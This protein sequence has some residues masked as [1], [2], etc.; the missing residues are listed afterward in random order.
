[1]FTASSRPH[2]YGCSLI[3]LFSSFPNS[4][5]RCCRAFSQNTLKW[6][7]GE[8]SLSAIFVIV[9]SFKLVSV[10]AFTL[11]VKVDQ[12]FLTSLQWEALRTNYYFHSPPVTFSYK[13][14]I[15]KISN[16]KTAGKNYLFIYDFTMFNKI[17]KGGIKHS[18]IALFNL[19]LW[20]CLQLIAQLL[21]TITFIKSQRTLSIQPK[22]NECFEKRFPRYNIKVRIEFWSEKSSHNSFFLH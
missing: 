21:V 13:F 22:K 12:D 11:V 3:F 19:L 4:N 1:M 17:T 15:P 14:T 2:V 7:S 18:T 20:H 8:T 16:A 5:C 10:L 9:F 6:S